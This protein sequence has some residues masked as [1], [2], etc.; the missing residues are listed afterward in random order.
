MTFA[1][2]LILRRHSVVRMLLDLKIIKHIQAIK[3]NDNAQAVISLLDP[4]PR[5][6]FLKSVFEPDFFEITE[7]F[8]KRKSTFFDLGANMG[9]CSFGLATGYPSLDYHLFEANP[10]LISLLKKSIE[11]H[12]THYFHLNHCCISDTHGKTNFNLE[13]NQSG[14]SHVCPTQSE[15]IK[16]PNLVLDD[17]C[18]KNQINCIDFAK[19]D[20]EGHELPALQGWQKNLSD[21][22]V[23]AIYVEIIPEN[24]KRYGRKTNAPLA[25][26]ESLGY[27]LFLCKD[28]DFGL[29]GEHPRK[30]RLKK[31]TPLLAK[32]RANEY[33]PTFSTDVLALS[34]N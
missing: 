34:P 29:F 24:Q 22:R 20:I 2:P 25:Y 21:H 32:F 26:L 3:F 5:N 23:K 14:Q 8:L 19:I 16:I 15:G 6:V 17:Y 9:F 4:E 12:P 1:L 33:P 30:N 10:N 11:L 27:S 28:S 13:A 7:C 31:S 18:D